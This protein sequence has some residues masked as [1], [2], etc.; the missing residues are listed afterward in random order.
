MAT[1]FLARN[2][3][4][5]LEVSAEDEPLLFK[6]GAASVMLWAEADHDVKVSFRK[7]KHALQVRGDA[8]KVRAAR[9]DLERFLHGGEG[10]AV[11]KFAVNEHAI[12]SV[13]GKGG[14]NIAKLEQEFPGV[15]VRPRSSR[16]MTF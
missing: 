16:A 12:G 11:C 5:E 15:L 14:S 7:G 6:G 10:V 13:I 8:E 3:I 1:A 4:A 2:R 9:D